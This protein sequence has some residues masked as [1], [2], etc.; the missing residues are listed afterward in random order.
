MK[1]LTIITL[2]LLTMCI[3]CTKDVTEQ[4]LSITFQNETITGKYTGQ[5]VDNIVAADNATFTYKDGDN[6]LNYTGSF[7]DGQFSGNGTLESNMYVVHFTDFDRKGEYKGDVVDGIP[8][9]NGSFTAT[10]DENETYT[11]EGEWDNGIF[12][13]YGK[14]TFE[15]PSILKY[16]GTYVNGEFVPTKLEFLKHI[17]QD[18]SDS[19][20]DVPFTMSENTI[21]FINNNDSIFPTNNFD[22]IKNLVDTSIEFKHLEKNINNYDGKLI[23]FDKGYV[24]SI[25]EGDSYGRDISVVQVASF[26]D[27]FYYV[28][29]FGKLDDIFEGDDIVMYGLPLGT[30]YFTN[31]GNTTTQGIVV[32]GSY[33]TK[34]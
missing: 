5:L 9:G 13:G 33:I 10:N 34:R 17:G 18:I 15:D 6:Y 27:G 1:K 16:E 4:D 7:K 30:T 12:N 8:K 3:G 26:G 25:S 2:L 29:Y 32:L 20:T 19:D 28:Y 24:A 21:K 22:N 14:R 11:Y 31:I 23:K